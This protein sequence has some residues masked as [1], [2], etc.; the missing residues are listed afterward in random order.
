[1]RLK[2]GCGASADFPDNMLGSVH[3]DKWLKYHSTCSLAFLKTGYTSMTI[4]DENIRL[5]YKTAKQAELV[6]NL[7]MDIIDGC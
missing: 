1:M 7:L 5:H 3:A 6:G 4:M 2:C